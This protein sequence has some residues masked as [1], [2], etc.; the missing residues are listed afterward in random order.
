VAIRSSRIA[1][2]MLDR[3][4]RENIPG[5]RNSGWGIN[6]LMPESFRDAQGRNADECEPINGKRR[7]DRGPKAGAFSNSRIASRKMKPMAVP[8]KIAAA[9]SVTGDLP[10]WTALP[11]LESKY[12]PRKRKIRWRGIKAVGA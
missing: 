11:T 8:T 1:F 10:F 6:A 2:G 5:Q 4:S 3:V 9:L 12:S 7:R